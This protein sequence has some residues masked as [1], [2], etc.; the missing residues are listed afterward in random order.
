MGEPT[1]KLFTGF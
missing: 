1:K